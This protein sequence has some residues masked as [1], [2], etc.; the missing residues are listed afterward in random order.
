[1]PE[2]LICPQST[3]R[4]TKYQYAGQLLTKAKPRPLKD[5]KGLHTTYYLE[6]TSIVQKGQKRDLQWEL[7]LV[8]D[9]QGFGAF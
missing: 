6:E 2:K 3:H 5:A 1:M 7:D 4:Q 8:F 9:V